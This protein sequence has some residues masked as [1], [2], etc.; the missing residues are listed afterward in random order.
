[1]ICPWRLSE[2]RIWPPVIP[3]AAHQRS[4]ASLTQAGTA[5]V[6]KRPCLPRRSTITQQP[7]RCWRCATVSATH[8]ECQQ[9]AIAPTFHHLGKHGGRLRTIA[10]PAFRV[11][12]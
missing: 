8:E 4:T 9:G 11:K 3:A 2:R 1:V 10:V 5:I 7:S 12:Q 6:R